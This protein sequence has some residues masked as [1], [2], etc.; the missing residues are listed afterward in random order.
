MPS[1][2]GPLPLHRLVARLALSSLLLFALLAPT[3]SLARTTPPSDRG[4]TRGD[5]KVLRADLRAIAR[6]NSEAAGDR[7]AGAQ[8]PHALGG[9]ARANVVVELSAPSVIEVYK[10]VLTRH[11]GDS[12]AAIASASAAAQLSR[13]EREQNRVS[14]ALTSAAPDAAEIYRVQRVYN[15]M[16][17]NV[18]VDSLEAIAAIPGVRSIKP[19]TRK[20]RDN[21]AGPPL[22]EAP[23]VWDSL[24][25]GATGEGVDIGIID[26]GIDYIHTGFG[27]PGSAAYASNNGTVITDT[28]GGAPLF[29]TAKVVGGYDF[30]GDAY[31]ADYDATSV[32]APDPD[33]MDC[34]GHG[35]HV[36]GT[37]AGYGV[38]ADGSTYAGPYNQSVPFSSLR[39]GPG[40][41]PEA[42]LYALRVFG[43][44]G[45]TD[46][47][48]LAIEWATDPNGDGN[49]ADHLDVIN[50][51]LGSSYG[52]N[53]D[54]S[55][56]AS[57]RAAE[58]GVIVVTSAGNSDDS[59]YN[60]GSPGVATRAMTTASSVDSLAIVDGFSVTS[61]A[62]NGV[63]IASF[64][65]AY[66][67]AGSAPS[68]APLVFV[69]DYTGCAAATPAQAGQISGKVVLVDWAPAGSS[70][71]YCGSATRAESAATAGAAGII[72]ASGQPY[73]DTAITG[74]ATLRAVFTTKTVGD[75]LKAALG[76][77]VVTIGF[78]KTYANSVASVMPEYVD[79]LSDFSSRGP[80]RGDSWLKP[81]LAM[82][83]QTIFSVA[84]STGNQGRSLN[85]TSMAAPHAAGM[86][87]LLHELNPTWTVEELKA[88]AMNTAANDLFTGTNLSG[89]PF[90]PGRVG[91]GR[92]NALDAATSEVV[93]FN[94]SDDGAVSISFGVVEVPPG[95]LL[96]RT[97]TIQVVN[98][99]SAPATYNLTYVARVDS[100]GVG[101]TLSDSSVTVP[102]GGS[103][104][105]IVTLTADPAQMK[106]SVRDTSVA[107]KQLDEVRHW[108]GEEAGFVQM[109]A[110][111][112]P[113]LRV[114]V[115]AAPRL[116]A[117]MAT[118]LD[119]LIL[120]A[121]T[122]ALPLTLDGEGVDSNP[123]SNPGT[124]TED[125]SL[126]SVFEL[127]EHS[128][129]ITPVGAITA[130]ADIQ[131]VG[132]AS[133]IAAAPS[134]ADTL[135]A[136]GIASYGDFSIG[137]AVD[138]EFD[139]YI[140]TDGSGLGDDLGGA[141]FVMFNWDL[142]MAT[143]GDANDVYVTALVNL[144]NN[145]LALF[146]ANA[147]DANYNTNVFNNNVLMMEVTAADL[148]LTAGNTRIN[149][150]VVSFAREAEGV[151][152]STAQMSFDVASPGVSTANSIY[153]DLPDATFNVAYNTPAFEA[154][155]SRGLLLLHHHNS[156]AFGRAETL[157][158][159]VDLGVS[160]SGPDRLLTPSGTYTATVTN[161]SPRP[162]D[163][164]AV[165][166][167]L[168]GGLTFVEAT[169]AACAAAGGTLTCDV[170]TVNGSGTRTV[171]MKLAAVAGNYEL[172]ASVSGD[173]G[174]PVAAN[175][176][177]AL[178]SVLVPGLA[179]TQSGGSTA[180][181]VGGGTD[182][183]S[184]ALAAKP[185][186]DVTLT[187]TPS[188]QLDL[189]LGAGRPV[190]LTFT[191][192][193]WN[194]AQTV[195]VKAVGAP[196]GITQATIAHTATGG[197]FTGMAAP[198]LTVSVTN[199]FYVNLPLI[200]R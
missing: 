44:D 25:L 37:A 189:G 143:G 80:R 23:A 78:D 168:P 148:G 55:A 59:Y 3:G 125:V 109:T 12:G 116:A 112:E 93:A 158:A 178:I 57:N 114:P 195:T 120:P 177:S 163:N 81:D 162:A 65:F 79:T 169:D 102:A 126:V 171:A 58:L 60:T 69:A 106:R 7:S 142:G 89:T 19:L 176:T 13:V 188:G 94:A 86:M 76:G 104:D 14:A 2:Q 183:Y 24:G 50:M 157:L 15:G 26:T 67:W 164:V 200:H 180:V 118:T 165:T 49:F 122:G 88:L 187:A 115:H 38:N 43:C 141:E 137:S 179:V 87:A 18:D 103:A 56:I 105:V 197:G 36:A 62:L 47:T 146:Y 135:V 11:T 5:I 155:S 191:T 134:L 160:L 130:S 153:L 51:S 41:A 96:T 173:A 119:E 75:A 150:A 40:V 61:G 70:T 33:P 1:A 31:D 156:A 132:V 133:D 111:G 136:F 172:T 175:D 145:D 85:G 128:P 101:V 9:P 152:D 73:F 198:A 149:Y 151:V 91:A 184:V 140:D 63:Q 20:Y 161:S 90:G 68:S 107:P 52:S 48:D 92:G 8:R 22:I 28:F 110:A 199:K 54:S 35:S 98:K 53:D 144:T 196:G 192:A 29:P 182:S 64:S 10:R 6:A 159:P 170:G 99:G 34:N 72:M 42:N 4:I 30:V 66:N 71:Q 82:P 124:P 154:N 129:R 139:I 147:L 117:Q 193:N 77:G 131:Y 138:T 16:A 113:T 186:G 17:L 185:T 174:D 97:K 39:I 95:A 83:G 100:P 27:G 21:A 108:L 32:P 123:A 121:G 84:T 194:T 190:S 166:M 74:S 46:V 167:P 45:S 181:V 127:Q